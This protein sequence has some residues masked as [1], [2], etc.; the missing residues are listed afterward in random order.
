MVLNYTN[1]HE[2]SKILAKM[3]NKKAA[4][5][6]G[7]L[8]CCPPVIENYLTNCF[9]NSIEKQFFPNSLKIAKVI[10]PYKKGNANDPGNYRPISLLSSL[11]KVFEK[12]LYNRMVSF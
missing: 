5:S 12:L 4:V 7:I 10:P 6:N 1:Q 11:S 3:K 9:N 2:I 8:K